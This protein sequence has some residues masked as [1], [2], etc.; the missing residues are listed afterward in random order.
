M[1]TYIRAG[2]YSAGRYWRAIAFLAVVLAMATTLFAAPARADTGIGRYTGNLPST[3]EAGGAEYVAYADESAAGLVHV[4]LLDSSMGIAGSWYDGASSTF[5]GTG[6]SIA[7][8]HGQAVVVAWADGT[9]GDIQ[10]AYLV[11]NEFACVT[12]MKNFLAGVSPDTPYGVTNDTPYLS[13]EGLD[14]TGDLLLTWVDAASAHV[15]ISVIDPPN[16]GGCAVNPNAYRFGAEPGGTTNT[17]ET[18]SDGPSLVVSGYSGTSHGSGE[19]VWLM[20]AGTDGGGHLNIAAYTPGT[21]FYGP[22]F[23]QVSKTTEWN[24]STLTDTAAAYNTSTGQVWLTYCGTNHVVYYQ[25]FPASS[26]GGGNEQTIG[27][28]SCK[29]TSTTIGGVTYYSGGVG[30]SYDY[31]DGLMLVS[32]PDLSSTN[33]QLQLL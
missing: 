33:I 28:A 22:V 11:N 10:I 23:N 29:V 1:T 14:G 27:S 6:P 5:V 4:V 17:G 7:S 26:S 2:R 32:W 18:A 24:H 20:W 30:V 15:H 25:D 8:V 21:S 9:T 31:S 13:T 3:T 16:A 19:T 12:D